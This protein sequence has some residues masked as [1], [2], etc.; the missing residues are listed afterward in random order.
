M[1]SCGR[2]SNTSK[3]QYKIKLQINVLTNSTKNNNRTITNEMK[4]VAFNLNFQHAVDN[5]QYKHTPVG[6]T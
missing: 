3:I 2:I 4:M 5:S 6:T 1:G